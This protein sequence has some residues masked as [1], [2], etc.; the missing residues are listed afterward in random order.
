MQNTADLIWEYEKKVPVV[1]ESHALVRGFLVQG[2]KEMR[3]RSGRVAEKAE[4]AA[5]DA[6][7]SV[8]GWVEKGK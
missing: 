7:K 1:S 5:E 2:W 6:R 4:V 3:Q 8:E